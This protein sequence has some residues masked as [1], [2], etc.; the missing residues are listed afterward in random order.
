[1]FRLNIRRLWA[2]ALLVT[3][4][5]AANICARQQSAVLRG[6]VVDELG[7]VIVGAHVTVV[8]AD[9]VEKS[10]VSNGDGDYAIP[11][12]VPGKYT[13]RATMTGFNVFEAADVE[14][15]ASARAG[16]EIKLSAALSLISN[17]A[18][19]GVVTSTSAASKTLKPVM[20]AR[21]VYFPG[22]SPAMT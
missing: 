10:V 13:L 1:M 3:L 22:A 15:T 8:G 12:L 19:D 6:R 20:V 2:M 16:F 17:P 21:R 9:G 18:R 4:L 11:G 5:G 14:V 7:A